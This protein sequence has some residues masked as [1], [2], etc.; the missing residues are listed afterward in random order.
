MRTFL[1]LRR[2]NRRELPPEFQSDDNRYADEL[3]E[4]FVEKYTQPGDKVLDIFAGYGTTLLVAEDM[5]RVPF[6]VE[7]DQSRFEYMRS[8]VRHKANVIHGNSSK[9]SSYEL[10]IVDFVMTSPYYMAQDYELNPLN[11]CRTAGDY[12][13]YLKDL[14][15]IFVQLKQVLKVDGHL[16]VE[17]S[18]LKTS[19]VTTF[20]WDLAK[21]ISSVFYFE[22]EVVVGWEAE[23]TGCGTYGYGYDHSY[24]LVFRNLAEWHA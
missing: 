3:V 10:P 2:I 13:G 14:R 17:A 4:Y 16:V 19:C 12:K 5:G 23:D 1:T 18:N 15:G 22:G 6:G 20:A 24:C 7:Y 21:E 11:C 8:Q 9:L